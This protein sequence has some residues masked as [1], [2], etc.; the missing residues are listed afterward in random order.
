D[1]RRYN[2]EMQIFRT[3]MKTGEG[4]EELLDAI[5]A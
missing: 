1:M 4:I 3:N 2:P 5:L